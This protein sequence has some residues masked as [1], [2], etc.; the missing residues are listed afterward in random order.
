MSP[1][2]GAPMTFSRGGRRANGAPHN[3]PVSNTNN[4]GGGR[5]NFQ[6]FGI[7]R[8]VRPW[9]GRHNLN[10]LVHP[11]QTQNRIQHNRVGGNGTGLNIRSRQSRGN[12]R[13]SIVGGQR[14]KA[15]IGWTPENRP[16]EILFLE[17]SQN[18][19]AVDE[20]EIYVE[21]KSNNLQI[22]ELENWNDADLDEEVV[23]NI[24]RCNFKSLRG[25]QKIALPIVLVGADLIAQCET[26]SAYSHGAYLLP[27][28]SSCVAKSRNVSIVERNKQP[29]ALVLVPT[30]ELVQQIY[31][32]IKLLTDGINIF[33]FSWLH[34]FFFGT[35]VTAARAFGEFN[36]NKNLDEISKGC[37][38]IVGTHGRVLHLSE[39]Q[40]IYLNKI[41]FLIFDECDLLLERK[42]QSRT[43]C[44]K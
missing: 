27:I 4:H 20:E 23:V 6:N 36:F 28:V 39:E 8:I 31:E 37:D 29:T 41:L 18:L 33:I 34:Y 15:P 16:A 1:Q 26:C 25:I 32:Q 17:K 2:S 42:P 40:V 5:Q 11:L 44:R 35:D 3:P 38:I 7:N 9:G 24:K 22:V 14:N 43:Q 30:H 19:E 21:K 12:T 13:E 10:N